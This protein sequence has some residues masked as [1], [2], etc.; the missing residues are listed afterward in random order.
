LLAALAVV[1]VASFLVT[2]K[3]LGAE[4]QREY[5]ED[6]ARREALAREEAKY[7]RQEARRDLYV[8]NVCQAQWAWGE[9]RVDIM[10]PLFEEVARRRPADADVWGV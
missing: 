10:L 1:I 6:T 5:A 7:H 9:G 4:H 8:A 2:R 3:W